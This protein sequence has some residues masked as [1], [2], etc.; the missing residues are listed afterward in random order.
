MALSLRESAP[1]NGQTLE[2]EVQSNLRY[3]SLPSTDGFAEGRGS[4][5]YT[6]R[7]GRQ[8]HRGLGQGTHICDSSMRRNNPGLAERMD[9]VACRHD[10][11]RTERTGRGLC[12][13]S[14]GTGQPS[15][16]KGG[17][18]YQM[19]CSHGAA[20]IRP[21][22]DTSLVVQYNGDLIAS[23]WVRWFKRSDCSRA[24]GG[25]RVRCREIETRGLCCS[26]GN[27]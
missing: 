17:R 18:R 12:I 4:Q 19:R 22:A 23:Q 13:Y 16:Y 3:S 21:N 10:C 27:Y 1:R 8:W 5:F 11:A 26:L 9:K 25:G 6:G 24:V 14:D 2:Q 7:H 15:H 20:F